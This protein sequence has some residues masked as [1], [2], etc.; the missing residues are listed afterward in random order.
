MPWSEMQGDE[1]A[2]FCAKCARTV[3]N[4]SAMSEEERVALLKSAKPGELCV[5]YYA[6]LSGGQV[7]VET[8]VASSERSL[9]PFR[10]AGYA[11]LSAGALA[12]A[13][14]CSPASKP[15]QN[16]KEDVRGQPAKS[17]TVNGAPEVMI[18]GLPAAQPSPTTPSTE[19]PKPVPPPATPSGPS[20]P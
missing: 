2:R 8:P 18:L 5:A 16:K 9:H 11:A 1:S 20:S 14:G 17:A 3:V 7:T 13:V 10:Q 6:R 12:L 15:A 19:K 4:L